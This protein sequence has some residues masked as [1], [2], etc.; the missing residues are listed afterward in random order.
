MVATAPTSTARVGLHPVQLAVL[1]MLLCT[2]FWGA[3]YVVG[4]LAVAEAP[5]LV[6][7][8]LRFAIAGLVLTAVMAVREPGLPRLERRDWLLV[9]GLG[10]TGVL[11]FNAFTFQGFVY[12]PASDAALINPSLNPIVTALLAAVIFGEKLWRTKLYGIALCVLGIVILFASHTGA[13]VDSHARL[14]GDLCFVL[15]A[16]SWSAYTLLTRVAIARFSSLALTTY[17]S[18]AGLMMLLPL[19]APALVRT[20]W[21]ALG[22]TFWGSVLMLALLCTVLS[23]LLWNGAIRRAGAS[24]A[25]SFLPLVPVFG[26]ALGAVVLHETLGLV[27]LVVAA[28]AIG[29]VYLANKPKPGPKRFHFRRTMARGGRAAARGI[30]RVLKPAL[31]AAVARA[32]ASAKRVHAPTRARRGRSVA[33]TRSLR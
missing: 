32:S 28:C 2:F 11:A 4:K 14:L 16:L 19:S 22:A 30:V 17:T 31:P 7:A 12:A 26:L 5:P 33:E 20:D 29:G 1:Q 25:A 18:L 27:H 10:F 15:S 8:T 6:V 24:R 23:F 9:L 21:A 3:F 13:A